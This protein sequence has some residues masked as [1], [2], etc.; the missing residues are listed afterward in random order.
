MKSWLPIGALWCITLA[1]HL[2][3]AW[4]PWMTPARWF[5]VLRGMEG[6]GLFLLLLW[7]IQ[8]TLT[9]PQ[10]LALAT[11][12]L[13][14]AT[15][16]M[17]T[18]ICGLGWYWGK[19][20]IPQQSGGMLCEAAHPSTWSWLTILLAAVVLWGVSRAQRRPDHRR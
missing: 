9:R 2:G 19:P 13:L 12:S 15:M 14:G 8:C 10:F 17:L 6:A 5:Y 16:E 11:V 7:A 1:T 3:F 4:L 18:A 20:S